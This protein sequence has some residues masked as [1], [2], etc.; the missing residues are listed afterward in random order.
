MSLKQLLHLALA[1]IGILN[2]MD[3]ADP[4]LRKPRGLSHH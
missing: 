4:A 2:S 3:P 1:S